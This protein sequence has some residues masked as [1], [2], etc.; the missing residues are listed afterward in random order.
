MWS[1]FRL[2]IAAVSN[3]FHANVL[4]PYIPS[5]T[6]MLH[7]W[8]LSSGVFTGLTRFSAKSFRC[9]RKTM[10]NLRQEANV[11]ALKHRPSKVSSARSMVHI[12]VVD[13]TALSSQRASHKS[14]HILGTDVVGRLHSRVPIVPCWGSCRREGSRRRRRTAKPQG[15]PASDA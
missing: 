3:A 1:T 11:L 13:N 12:A 7:R 15:T 2:G 10:S 9:A 4:Q 14:C 8:T 6:Q 5:K